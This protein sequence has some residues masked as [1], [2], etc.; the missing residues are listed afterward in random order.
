MAWFSWP[1]GKKTAAAYITW[2]LGGG[3]KACEACRKLD[4]TSW[5][6]GHAFKGPPLKAECLCPGGCTCR[7]LVVRMDE[8]WGPGNAEWITKRGGLVTGAQMDKF[9]S[10]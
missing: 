5:V 8:A 1:F 10:N 7:E 6:P 2:H 3:S 9:L 4:G